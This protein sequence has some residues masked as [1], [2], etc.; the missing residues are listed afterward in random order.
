M[1]MSFRKR[2][3]MP[4]GEAALIVAG[5]VLAALYSPQLDPLGIAY[6]VLLGRFRGRIPAR[7]GAFA[8]SVIVLVAAIAGPRFVH[9]SSEFVRLFALICA[10]WLCTIF[11]SSA[12]VDRSARPEPE[13]ALDDRDKV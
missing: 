10:M 3:R 11:A 7:I 13:G 2:N 4:M 5:G 12:K 8:F 9:S 1:S 6:V